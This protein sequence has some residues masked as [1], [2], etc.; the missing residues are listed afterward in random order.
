M[1]M[2]I[3]HATRTTLL[4]FISRLDAEFGQPARI[5]LIGETTQVFERW[6]GWTTQIEFTSEVGTR[7]REAFAGALA[8]V[9]GEMDVPVYD[10]SPA[11]LIPLP[12]GYERRA[13]PATPEPTLSL[14]HISIHHFDSYSVAFRYIAR[15]DEPDYHIV[16]M[17]LKRGWVTMEEMD[18]QLSELLPRFT[19]ETIQQDPAEFRRKYKG[20]QQMS[21]AIGPYTNHRPT[22]V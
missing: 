15:G 11:A 14:R 20:L 19:A 4:D 8:R 13:R 22:P 1:I 2:D 10:E 18:R 6:R 17:L 16:L 3:A 5:Y 9:A 7:H 21:R 12:D